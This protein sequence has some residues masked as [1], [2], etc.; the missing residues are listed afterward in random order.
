MVHQPRDLSLDDIYLLECHVY[1]PH[2]KS[3]LDFVHLVELDHR[4]HPARSP[5][6]RPLGF[7]G[8]TGGRDSSISRIALGVDYDAR[9]EFCT[10]S[11]NLID[12]HQGQ[13]A[14]ENVGPV[15]YKLPADTIACLQRLVCLHQ[16][17]RSGT[18]SAAS[19]RR[20]RGRRLH[21]PLVHALLFLHP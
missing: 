6:D 17:R 9:L 2:G 10:L 4:H 15:L 8:A 13:W 1:K 14:T 7:L 3:G 12:L 19:S 5:F 20:P 21:A 18:H 11:G 16:Q